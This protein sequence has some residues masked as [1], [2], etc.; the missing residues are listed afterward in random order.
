MSAARAANLRQTGVERR[1]IPPLSTPPE[2]AAFRLALLQWYDRNKRSLPWRDAPDLYRVWLSEI[3]LQ[4][5]RVSQV[6]PYYEKFVSIFPSL[7]AL[8]AADLQAVLMVWEGLGYY[9]RARNLHKAAREVVAA[10]KRPQSCADLRQLPGIGPY[11]ARAIASIV[12]G[13]PQA[14][15]DGNVR[16]VLARLCLAET[17]SA[18]AFQ[19]AADKLLD[20]VR[21]GDY[22]QAIMDLGA[23]VC[24]PRKPDCARCPVQPYCL[25]FAS[26]TPEAWPIRIQKPA[27]PHFDVAVGILRDERGRVFIQRR[28]AKAMLGGLWELPGGKREPGESM[29]DACHRELREELS[30]PVSVG[31]LIGKVNHAYTHFRITL[32]A[33]ECRILEGTPVSAQGLD[34]AWVLP[35]ALHDYPFPRANRRILDLMVKIS[36]ATG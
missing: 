35:E 34:T 21:P 19:D 24:T 23:Q 32:W 8:A 13:E 36:N 31:R 2:T 22:N 28:P 26:G 10:G 4:Q 29:E 9:A 3:M 12:M 11:T 15:V 17:T 16:R 20:R 5:T 18:S 30:I 33:F 14:A 6:I 1:G 25:A 27:V 7:E